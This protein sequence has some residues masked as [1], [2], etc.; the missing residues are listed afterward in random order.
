[1]ERPQPP[2]RIPSVLLELSA[3]RLRQIIINFHTLSDDEV[4]QLL[5]LT[6][7]DLYESLI[8][9]TN[10]IRAHIPQL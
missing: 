4:K 1:M 7:R 10:E 3:E 6:H 9:Y 2:L 8:F 5:V